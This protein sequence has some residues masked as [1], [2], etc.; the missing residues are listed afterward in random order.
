[1]LKKTRRLRCKNRVR[2]KL[3]Q[4]INDRNRLSICK[5]NK[6]IYVQLINDSIAHT[7]AAAST[8][9]KLFAEKYKGSIN[10]SNKM[11]AKLLAEMLLQRVKN[12]KISMDVVFDRRH[13]KYCGVVKE[14]ASSARSFGLRF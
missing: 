8:Q 1:M 13:H 10:K 5:T 6:H 11:A 9:E 2:F 4:R 7:L 3:S 12:N 14:F